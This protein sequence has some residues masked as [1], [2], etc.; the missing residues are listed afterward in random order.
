MI[1]RAVRELEFNPSDLVVTVLRE[2]EDRFNA[3]RGLADA[4][5]H[6]V[7]TVILEKPTRSQSETVIE[8]LKQAEINEPFLVK[9]SDNSF[10]IDQIDSDISYVTVS[11]LNDFDLI[12]PRNK[13]Y[14]TED[15]EGFITCIR[16][17]RV[18]S[19]LF[20]VGGYFFRSPEI[21]MSAFDKLNN[22]PEI[23]TSEIYIS[24]VISYL[25]MN[26]EPF[27]TK[28]A[29]DYQDWGTIHEWRRK[30]ESRKLFFLS[31]DGFLF[32]RGSTNFSPSFRDVTPNP[33]AVETAR[34]L[35]RDGHR[36]VYLSIRPEDLKSM[37]AQALRNSGLP[38]G[39]LLMECDLSQ[40][41]L[42]TS[43]HASMPYVTSKAREVNPDDENLIEKLVDLT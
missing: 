24:E 20:S 19:D 36:I 28:R 34:T 10:R 2:H 3:S 35:A 32:G 14:V 5:G 23:A 4:F 39:Q 13:S 1:V 18:I 17:K 7:K 21:F 25:L 22:A 42:V 37:T 40:W 27:K 30:L 15:H 43:P 26:G 38:E 33:H 11:S 12:N 8:T 29:A 41:T 6:A 9:D 16:E 31:V